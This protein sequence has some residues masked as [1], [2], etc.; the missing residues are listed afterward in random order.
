M[1]RSELFPKAGVTSGSV[2]TRIKKE[3]IESGFIAET[4][5]F[6][7]RK[8]GS[9]FR[10]SDEYSAF[11]LKWYEEI[12]NSRLPV[13]ANH[14]MM[15]HNSPQ[16]KI[17]AGYAF[18]NVCLNHIQ[19]IAKAL[20]FSG[21]IYSFSSWR[22]KPKAQNDKGVQIDILIERSDN[23]INLCEIKFYDGKFTVTKEYAEKLLYKKQKFIEV[24]KTRKTVF[25][26]LIT[27]FGAKENSWFL[28]AVNNQLS[29]NDLFIPL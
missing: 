9:L 17:W 1:E 22:Y 15:L 23:C 18:E 19:Q 11:Y 8:Q 21:I 3:L 16:F 6:G 12:K 28:E 13:N 4:S 29:V 25:T 20:G 2:Q 5:P 24:T 10:L 26:T 7:K 14:W 27:S